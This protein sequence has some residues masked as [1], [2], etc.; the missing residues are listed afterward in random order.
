M[1]QVEGGGDREPDKQVELLNPNLTDE[2]EENDYEEI[3]DEKLDNLEAVAD[4]SSK[5]NNEGSN[6]NDVNEVGESEDCRVV[7]VSLAST[8]LQPVEIGRTIASEHKHHTV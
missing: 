6:S 7:A 1:D 5:D 3:D 8:M 4:G 2:E